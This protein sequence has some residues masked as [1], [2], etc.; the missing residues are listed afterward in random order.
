MATEIDKLKREI[1]K[2]KNENSDLKESYKYGTLGKN[3]VHIELNK[4]GDMYYNHTT[5]MKM[6]ELAQ[7]NEKL[8]EVIDWSREWL[9]LC[10]DDDG[11]I[12]NYD[13]RQLDTR[14]R[15]ERYITETSSNP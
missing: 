8:K 12:K 11:N 5:A 7:E 6:M 14:I 15:P 10:E 2:L 1:V 4:Q 13:L 3:G 9:E